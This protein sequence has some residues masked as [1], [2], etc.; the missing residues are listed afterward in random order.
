MSRTID[1]ITTSL[2]TPEEDFMVKVLLALVPFMFLSVNIRPFVPG[3]MEKVVGPPNPQLLS[4]VSISLIV[5][6]SPVSPTVKFP[7]RPLAAQANEDVR[8]V[9]FSGIWSACPLGMLVHAVTIFPPEVN[10]KLPT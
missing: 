7:D 4:M 10:V 9:S 3:R 8:K 6:K 2:A 5:R 1:S